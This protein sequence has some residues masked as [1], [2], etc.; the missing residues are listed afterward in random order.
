MS[1]DNSFK[2]FVNRFGLV[3]K[4]LLF[5]LICAVIISGIALAL[6]YTLIENLVNSGFFDR[7]SEFFVANVLNIRL[8]YLM[9][10][11]SII[12]SEFFEIISLDL[13]NLLPLVI[14]LLVIVIILGAFMFALTDTPLT[15]CVYGYMGSCAKFGFT[16]CFIS[17]IGRSVKLSL[18]KMI[19][20]LPL[21]LL[22][23]AGFVYSFNILALGGIFNYIGP[24]IVLMVLALLLSLRY[25]FFCCWAPAIV[26]KN[27]GIWK[28]LK[29]NF[30]S[31]F[32]N[33]KTVWLSQLATIVILL[34]INIGVFILTAGIGCIF[35]I[36]ASVV[37]SSIV[38]NVL[39]FQ[40]NG[41]RYYID[42]EN[43]FSPK[44]I[45]EQEKLNTI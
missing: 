38:N 39:Y 6:C 7:I 37:Y 19:T 24:F 28:G 21:D 25:A 43:I 8:D 2:L 41:L 32:N 30:K 1:I 9:S 36:P 42:K 11:I 23:M 33:F 15:E 35:T 44:K 22:I 17:N 20:V 16:G 26:V 10:N 45:D 27:Q 18:C 3:W 13:A 29:D 14:V 12:I 34:V 40:L 31:I 4:V 5:Q